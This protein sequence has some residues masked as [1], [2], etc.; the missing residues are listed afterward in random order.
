[1]ADSGEIIFHIADPFGEFLFLNKIILHFFSSL[2][3]FQHFYTVYSIFIESGQLYMVHIIWNIFAD[4]CEAH[5]ILKT[6]QQFW[7]DRFYK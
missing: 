7:C 3:G 1:M 2:Y 4:A 6:F 5:K